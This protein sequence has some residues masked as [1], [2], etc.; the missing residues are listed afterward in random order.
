[1]KSVIGMLIVLGL[2]ASYGTF[3]LIKNQE[4]RETVNGRASQTVTTAAEDPE[5]FKGTVTVAATMT[6][7][8]FVGAGFL[9][10]RE[11]RKKD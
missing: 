1:M 7:I 9:T 2:F 10:I 4:F 6:I 5:K 11:R 3:T 8:C